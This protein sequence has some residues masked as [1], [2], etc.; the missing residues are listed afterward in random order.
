MDFQF[1]D[2]LFNQLMI[3]N[4]SVIVTENIAQLNKIALGLYEIENL[5]QEMV[6]ALR[7]IIMCCNVLYNRTDLTILPVEDGFYDLLLEKYKNYDPNFQVGSA[8]VDFVDLIENDIDNPRKVAVKPISFEIIGEKDEVHQE[9]YDNI[10]RANKPIL[11]DERDF[12]VNP[13]S[14]TDGD[15]SKRTHDTKHNHPSLVGTLDKSKFVL[16]KDAIDAGVFNDPNVKVLERDFFRDHINKGIIKPNQIIDVVCELKYDGISVEA[17]CGLEV[18]SA[19]T[20]GDTGIGEASDITPILKGYTF[21]HANCLIGENSIGVK[22]EAIIRKS[23]MIK[24]NEMRGRTYVNCRTAIIGLFGASDGYKFRDLITLVP[25]ALD[26]EDAPYISNRMEEIEFLNKVF[27]SNG[28]PL[29]YCY[30]RGTVEEVLYLIK[31][32]ADEA[33]VARDVLDF[34]YDGIVVS[35]LDEGIRNTLGRKN[36]INKYSMAVKF[37]ALEKQTIFRGYTY[38]VGQDGR[39]TPMIHYDPVEFMGSIHTKSTGSSL[40]RFKDLSLKYGDYINVTYVNDVMPYV[41]RLDCEAN[42]KNTNPIIEPIRYCP[43]CNSELKISDTGKLLFCP[44][45][46]CPGRTIQRMSNMM[47]KLNI[48]GFADAAFKT[49]KITHYYE[50]FNYDREWYIDKLGVADGNNFRNI[51]DDLQHGKLVFP[52]YMFMGALGFSNMAG[53]KWQVI[54][55]QISVRD[56]YDMYKKSADQN[57]FASRITSIIPKITPSALKTIVSEFGFF[58]KDILLGF[59]HVSSSVGSIDEDKPQI[60][61]SGI[62][63]QQLV[64]Q[65]RNQGYDADDSSVTKKTKILIVPYESFESGKVT[66]AKMYGAKIVPIQDF[67][68]NPSRYLEEKFIW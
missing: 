11:I 51:L 28:E 45:N 4:S 58:E 26:R 20:R 62:R 8:I 59:N 15:I 2:W 43:I 33:K 67:I 18:V 54:L 55:K 50:L 38:E 17:D 14:Y 22:F 52:D 37:D 27:I 13:I 25:L 1:I 30:M 56:L 12:H 6:E 44:N 16:N 63:N 61:F 34:M 40:E 7:K 57:D 10:L 5:D 46:E 65:L 23:D 35:Y 3:G 29:R 9:M 66:K 49:I 21:K 31:V 24:F 68:N 64:E 47:Q 32:F 60:R 48:K 53:K 42:R 36:Y 39:I 41:S 19:R